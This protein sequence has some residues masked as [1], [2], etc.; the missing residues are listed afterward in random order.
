M[1]LAQEKRKMGPY[2]DTHSI[3]RGNNG[4]LKHNKKIHAQK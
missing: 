2:I 3:G 4:K 1:I